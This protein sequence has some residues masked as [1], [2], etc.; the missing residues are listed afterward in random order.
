MSDDT[1]APYWVNGSANL[2]VE[3][4]DGKIRLSW[5]PAD[6]ADQLYG[7]EILRAESGGAHTLV[8]AQRY[9]MKTQFADSNAIAGVKYSYYV[10][11]YDVAGNRSEL[12]NEVTI[13]VPLPTLS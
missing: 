3:E 6:D 7:Y 12:S 5:E 4:R 11:A 1:E 13:E 8:Y 9:N 10:R 2:T